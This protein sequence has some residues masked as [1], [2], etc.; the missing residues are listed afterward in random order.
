M[1]RAPRR[2][3]R[4]EGRED[5]DVRVPEDVATVAV[6]GEPPG[7]HRGLPSRPR[8]PTAG[9]GR[10]GPRARSPGRPGSRCRHRASAA[11]RRTDARRAAP[12]TPWPRPPAGGPRDAT[13]GVRPGRRRRMPRGAP[14]C[15]SRRRWRAGRGRGPRSHRPPPPPS[16]PRRGRR[17]CRGRS[18]RPSAGAPPP[19]P[20]VPPVPPPARRGD[21]RS[22]PRR[23]GASGRPG[24]RRRGRGPHG[25]AGPRGGRAP[26]DRGRWVADAGPATTAP[27]GAVVPTP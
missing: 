4:H 16:A 5:E 13:A 7:A 25:E 19:P 24:R 9:R 6:T 21:A 26:A 23:T 12:R 20:P 18:R 17:G 8:A 11:P 15:P 27:G 14:R 3:H 22:P 2:G 1:A 10:T